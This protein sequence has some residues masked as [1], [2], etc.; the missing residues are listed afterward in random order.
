MVN[1]VFG[2]MKGACGI[3]MKKIPVIT[4]LIGIIALFPSLAFALGTGEGYYLTSDNYIFRQPNA[5]SATPSSYDSSELG[6]TVSGGNVSDTSEYAGVELQRMFNKIDDKADI[7]IG[8]SGNAMPE[9][10][11]ISIMSD[12]TAAVTMRVSGGKLNLVTSGGGVSLLPDVDFYGIKI[13]VDIANGTYSFM[14]NGKTVIQ[15]AAFLNSVDSL[16]R[17]YCVTPET[18]TG[19]FNIK[20]FYTYA[21]YVV[22]EW[23][24]GSR[25]A[26][27][28]DW[29]TMGAGVSV[30]SENVAVHGDDYGLKIDDGSYTSETGICKDI[31]YEGEDILAEYLFFSDGNIRDFG[32]TLSENGS[33]IIRIGA[34]GLKFGYWINGTFSAVYEMKPRIWYNA[35]IR[36]EGGSAKIY[37]NKK[38]VAENID[39]GNKKADRIKFSIGKSAVG[40]GYIDEIKVKTLK[41][42]PEDYVPEPVVPKKNGDYIIGMQSCSLWREGTH[43]G[44]DFVNGYKERTPYLGFY[45]EGSPEVADWEIKFL[46]EHGIDYQMYCW[47]RQGGVNTPIQRPAQSWALHDGFMESQYGKDLDFVI[48]W[49]NNNAT[50]VAGM[51]DWKENIVPYWIEWYFKDDRYLVVDNKPVVAMYWLPKLITNF[52]SL[53][54]T[55]AAMEYLDSVCRA[56]GFDGVYLLFQSD[57]RDPAIHE[58]CKYVGAD[59]VF[60]YTAKSDNAQGQKAQFAAQSKPGII[61]IVAS[62]GMGWDNSAWG[63]N[64][65][66]GWNDKKTQLDIMSWLHDEY[67]PKQKGFASKMLTIDN[68]NEFSEGHWY[69]PSGI[70]GFDYLDAVREV[71]TD[72]PEHTDTVPE[73]QSRFQH[74]YVQSRKVPKH[75]VSRM[76]D[77]EEERK[78]N[79]KTQVKYDF[80]YEEDISKCENG[81]QIDNFK[82][83]N[84]AVSGK[85]TGRDPK[86]Y[87]KNVNAS[88]DNIK[89]IRVRAK[90]TFESPTRFQIFFITDSDPNWDEKKSVH[91]TLD[92][93]GGWTE[94]AMN[95]AGMSGMKGKITDFRIDP[96]ELE[97]DFSVDS[98]EILTD[99]EHI[100]LTVDE[101]YAGVWRDVL[102]R[103]GKMYA[104]AV[105]Y[106][107]NF[108]Y[109]YALTLDK[110]YLKLLND[111]TG[112]RLS[113]ETDKNAYVIDGEAYFPLREV[114]ESAGF[115]VEWDDKNRCANVITV[116]GEITEGK[117]DPIGEWNF[118]TDGK[119]GTIS[120]RNNVANESVRG[121]IYT[122][123]ATTS[124]P[125]L[126]CKTDIIAEEKPYCNIRVKN[127]SQ[128]AYFQIF[129]QTESDKTWS[130]DK[131]A[132][133]KLST[134]D[135]DFKCYTVNMSGSAKWH[136]K[137]TELR[138]DPI[139]ASGVMAI[140]HIRFSSSADEGEKSTH[141]NGV[142]IIAEGMSDLKKL[143]YETDGVKAEYSE[144]EK[145]M[146]KY[147]LKLEKI[148]DGGILKIPC[149]I[150]KGK[151]Y[152]IDIQVKSDKKVTVGFYG[153][154]GKKAAAESTY[155]GG[156]WQRVTAA[157]N[158]D[159]DYTALYIAPEDIACIDNIRLYE[160]Q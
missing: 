100:D 122:F 82:I 50:G 127:K 98:I 76:L 95:A 150:Q 29:Q 148:N 33:D 59:A 117:E 36:I 154:S 156:A 128:G 155:N 103:D 70:A 3:K 146:G 48:M 96:G 26:V 73:N 35:Q 115:T 79:Y 123:T 114:A 67:M 53:E 107:A 102:Y 147:S 15:N 66:V 160:M 110:K 63:I 133:I 47:F 64:N 111:E 78:K 88:A 83:E 90:S 28:D 94:L 30:S 69:Y 2:L 74:L 104:P 84:G 55:K 118:D 116:S 10:G 43:M 31:S 149:T 152:K 89:E 22:N 130:E 157:L 81:E 125:I 142:N 97:G 27:P 112:A 138:I 46:S 134:G 1:T 19:S 34:D 23:F 39:T 75:S 51:D 85:S 25:S 132:K 143:A 41:Q 87:I 68:W 120:Q 6:G 54:N 17:F 141:E 131:S 37:L 49:E 92:N 140:D 16:N 45:D 18:S 113:F 145:Y 7:H 121:G 20:H 44:W 153:G 42:L 144:K 5:D 129:Y 61:D 80:T 12:Q 135:K 62:P 40:T 106:A 11:E 119:F 57:S 13:S 159:T 136:G 99:E 151:A 77:K 124:D 14:V 58:Q 4:V 65:R 137:I 105:E 38:L 139:D 9:G 60:C 158:A 109:N 56:E 108:G 32:A 71:F 72:E 24:L 8:V 21:G 86:F 93:S 91:T 52:G 101:K 126:L